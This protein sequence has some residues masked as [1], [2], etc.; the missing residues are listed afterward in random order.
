MTEFEGAEST[1]EVYHVVDQCVTLVSL[2]KLQLGMEALVTLELDSIL[3][4]LNLGTVE[5]LSIFIWATSLRCDD[6]FVASR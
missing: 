2:R 1:T 3:M 6:H 4:E 5:H